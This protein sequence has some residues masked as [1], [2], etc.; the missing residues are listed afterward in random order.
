MK[1]SN[2]R[3]YAILVLLCTAAHLVH[4]MEQPYPEFKYLPTITDLNE[5]IILFNA[6]SSTIGYAI[7]SQVPEVHKNDSGYFLAEK[8]HHITG[9]LGSCQMALEP[10]PYKSSNLFTLQVG[11][12]YV[13]AHPYFGPNI[14]IHGIAYRY[15]QAKKVGEPKANVTLAMADRGMYA[16]VGKNGRLALKKL[17]K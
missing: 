13:V 17:D 1:L 10:S 4:A 2:N 12:K 9:V 7:T 11:E 6:T 8:L 15:N 14:T 16:F 5:Y 3:T